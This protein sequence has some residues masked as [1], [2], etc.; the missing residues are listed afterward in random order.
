MPC[1]NPPSLQAARVLQTILNTPR[2]SQLLVDVR[3]YTGKIPQKE[4]FKLFNIAKSTGYKVLKQGTERRGLEVYNRGRKQV[5]TNHKCAAIKAVEDANFY[6]VSS[7]HYRVVKGI[8]LVNGL[9][10]VI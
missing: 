10:C 3:A 1:L 7:S 2:R 9:E 6:F 5:L 8:G 4:L